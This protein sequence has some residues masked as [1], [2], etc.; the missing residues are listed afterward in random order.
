MNIDLPAWNDKITISKEIYDNIR[1]QANQGLIRACRIYD[2]YCK[3]QDAVLYEIFISELDKIQTNLNI[4]A[5]ENKEWS[6][7]EA[8]RLIA[9]GMNMIEHGNPSEYQV[10]MIMG[11]G[12]YIG[13]N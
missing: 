12:G 6:K 13:G 3:T 11:L 4:I 8:E 5:Q 7:I 2:G 10:S 9:L 1:E